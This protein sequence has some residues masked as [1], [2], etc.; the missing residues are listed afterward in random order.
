[1][2]LLRPRV[3]RH[4]RPLMSRRALRIDAI[5]LDRDAR[6]EHVWDSLRFP[7]LPLPGS[8]IALPFGEETR[9]RFVVTRHIWRSEHW[10]GLALMRV[11]TKH[12]SA[13]ESS[14][15]SDDASSSTHG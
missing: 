11:G 13:S 12:V 3:S 10:V 14:D 5:F 1:M 6:L 15:R 7:E 2:S 9:A 4:V 8:V